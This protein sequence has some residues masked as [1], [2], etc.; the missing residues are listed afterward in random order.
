MAWTEPRPGGSDSITSGD[1]CV[2]WQ[3]VMA[4]SPVSQGEHQ[5]CCSLLPFRSLRKQDAASVI[6]VFS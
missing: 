6:F 5:I 3:L 2:P 4:Q 1:S